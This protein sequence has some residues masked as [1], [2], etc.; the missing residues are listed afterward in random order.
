MRI[1]M[2]DEFAIIYSYRDWIEL[3]VCLYLHGIC[4]G[5]IFSDCTGSDFA[6]FLNLKPT[7]RPIEKND[8]KGLQ[9][10]YLLAQLV[11]VIEIKESRKFWLLE[12]LKH[13]RLTYDYFESHRKDFD[14][15]NDSVRKDNIEFRDKVQNALKEAQKFR[16]RN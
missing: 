2:K 15:P 11:K 16:N 4:S 1:A 3:P 14:R 5:E 7:K 12:M 8:L 10:I 13:F 9:I 6:N